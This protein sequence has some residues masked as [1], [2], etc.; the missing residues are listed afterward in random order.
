MTLLAAPAPKVEAAVAEKAV[1]DEDIVSEKAPKAEFAQTEP[2]KV[3]SRPSAAAAP[4]VESVVA[5]RAPAS[6]GTLVQPAQFVEPAVAD[7]AA[8]VEP[9]TTV[10]NPAHHAPLAATKRLQIDSPTSVEAFRSMGDVLFESYAA[11]VRG[12]TKKGCFLLLLSWE[13]F[14][15]DFVSFGEALR[16]I[17][18]RDEHIYVFLSDSEPAPLFVIPFSNL[19]PILEDRLRPDKDSVTMNPTANTNLANEDLVTVLL[20]Y[21]SNR[22]QAFQFTFNTQ[23]DG[24]LAQRFFAAILGNK[25]ITPS[26]SIKNQDLAIAQAKIM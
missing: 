26:R 3:S 9:A 12:A 24:T 11:V 6:E 20:K 5:S 2:A 19:F 23:N 14:Q 22:K 21:R 7:P 15:R 1:C 17:M 16:Y 18:V 25:N 13:C 10:D 4:A 8:T